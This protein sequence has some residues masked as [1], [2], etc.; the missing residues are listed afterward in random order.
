MLV[1]VVQESRPEFRTGSGTVGTTV[2]RLGS[3]S[4]RQTVTVT[5]TDGTFKLGVD[6]VETA[7]I[8]FDAAAAD[9]QTA[10]E[11]ILGEGNVAVTGDAGGPW[12]VNFSGTLRWQPI[13]AMTVV[14]VNLEGEGLGIAVAVNERGRAVGWEVKKYIMLRANGA[15]TSIIMVGNRADNASEG[16]ILSAGQQSPAIFVDN[17][18]KVYIVGGAADQGYSWIAC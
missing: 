1:D 10:L 7:P 5:A 11:A 14:D 18:N 17:L 12:T 13:E 9:V 16:F 2:V 4:A 3:A 15:N 6:A 8:A